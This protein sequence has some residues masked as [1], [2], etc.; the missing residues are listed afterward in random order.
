L[1]LAWSLDGTA[2]GSDY[3]L[4]GS[5]SIPAGQNSTQ[6]NVQALDDVFA[7]GPETLLVQLYETPD[8]TLAGGPSSA[9]LTIADSAPAPPTVSVGGPGTVDAGS[10]YQLSIAA[11]DP[12]NDIASWSV[13]WGDGATET[14]TAA[15]PASLTHVYSIPPA[16]GSYWYEITVGV[17][18]S[19]GATGGS[20]TGVTVNAV[21]PP[22]PPPPPPAPPVV[23]SVSASPATVTE[24]D[25]Q[26]PAFTLNFSRPFACM[27]WIP[28]AFSGTASSGSDFPC[29]SGSNAFPALARSRI[30]ALLNC[31]LRHLLPKSAQDLRRKTWSTQLQCRQQRQPLLCRKAEGV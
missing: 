27:A 14:G 30:R 13:D 21:A 3:Y 11:S 23:V 4:Q 19:L 8:Y 24:G 2:G 18:D 10:P 1:N 9:E 15:P 5:F 17:A 12:N 31:H 16:C 22:P 7:E 26:Y 25:G 20:F 29:A 6:V 28:F